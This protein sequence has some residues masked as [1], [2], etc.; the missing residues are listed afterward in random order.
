MTVL[1]PL[2]QSVLICSATW[3]LWKSLR[4][5]IVKSSLDNLPGPPSKSL[6]RGHIPQIYGRHE[7]DFYKDIAQNYGPV[8]KLNG[9]LGNKMLYVFD[10][11][12]LHSVIVKDQDIYEEPAFLIKSNLSVFGPG[13]LSTLGDHHR[14]QR[15]LLNPV[16]S[17]AHMRHLTPVFYRISHQ[18]ERAIAARLGSGPREID[19][20]GWMGRTALELIGQGGLGYS[21]DPLV[22]NASIPVG[23]AIKTLLPTLASL[24]IYRRTVPYLFDYG[25]PAL[26]R[27]VLEHFPDRRVQALVKAVD[28]I[29]ATCKEILRDRKTALELGNEAIT[30]QIAEGKDILSVLIQANMNAMED[31]RLPDH[32]VVAQMRQVLRY[33]ITIFLSF[34]YS[35]LIFAAMDTTSNALSK[36]LN[37][38]A[39]HPEIQQKLRKEL[40][41][42]TQGGDIPYDD[43]VHL[44]YLDAVCR[45]TLRIFP[46][47]VTMMRETRKDAIMPLSEPIRGVDGAIMSEIHVPKGTVIQI[48]VHGSNW[49]KALWGEDA[50]EW[51][52]ERWLAPLP[53][54]LEEARIPGVYSHLM[55]FLG[56][57]RSCIGFKFSQIEMK[58][59]LAV[60]LP[61]FTFEL[62]KAPIVWN[63]AGVAYPTMSKEATKPKMMLKVGFVKD[64]QRS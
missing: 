26:R 37:L 31:D 40:V 57:G 44:P 47:A 58:A 41:E 16:F 18:L 43:L 32:E 15:K 24:A 3:F 35:T 51:K 22:E 9:L 20:L 30:H 14:K 36:T 13:L 61:V 64:M 42:A 46:P 29:D 1:I 12:A 55:T 60:L 54:A 21:F 2:L 7:W 25:T 39:E 63:I 33:V 10:P 59:V 11:L 5:F 6:W 50:L 53:A 52:P 28:I 8:V 45:E 17:I 38:L 48:G 34:P 62:P 19:V 4:Q 23:D 27:M 49:N 56:G